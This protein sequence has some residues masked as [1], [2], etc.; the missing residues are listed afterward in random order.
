[1]GKVLEIKRGGYVWSI[2]LDF[3]ATNRANFYKDDEDTTFQE[4][5]DY[6]MNESYAAIDWYANNM[7]WD[8]V[9]NY[10]K[11][12]VSKPDIPSSPEDSALENCETD[13]NICEVK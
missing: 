11:R 4:E 10:K 6:C 13:F 7:N 8:D 1:M 5:F 2:D 9:P 12:L 3:I